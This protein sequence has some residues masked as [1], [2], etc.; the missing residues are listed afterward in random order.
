MAIFNEMLGGGLNVKGCTADASKILDG[1]TAGVGNEIV[2]GTMPNN[3]DVNSAIA[4]GV[5]KEGYTSGGAIVNLVANNI[6]K[7][8]NIAGILGT[9]TEGITGW[10]TKTATTSATTTAL[11]SNWKIAMFNNIKGNPVIVVRAM[12]KMYVPKNTSGTGGLNAFDIYDLGT[13][14]EV[15]S[16]Q[17]GDYIIRA[18]V[19]SAN[20]FVVDP[21]T[22]SGSYGTQ[23]INVVYFY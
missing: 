2:D 19:T 17:G 22:F 21:Y 3:G 4:S 5:L 12:N 16:W 13:Y 8:V 23:N 20:N 14:F 6:A 1:Y 11:P 18:T 7:G 15:T 10:G 9:F